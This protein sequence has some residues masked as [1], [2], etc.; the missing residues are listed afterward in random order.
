MEKEKITSL[1]EFLKIVSHLINDGNNLLKKL[2]FLIYFSISSMKDLLVKF[3][4]W[5]FICKSS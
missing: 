2:L 5:T 4:S 1:A 3:P